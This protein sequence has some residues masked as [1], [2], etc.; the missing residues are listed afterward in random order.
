MYM[1][2]GEGMRGVGGEPGLYRDRLAVGKKNPWRGRSDRWGRAARDNR[3]REVM[4]R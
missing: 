1:E 3:W 2:I 4:D